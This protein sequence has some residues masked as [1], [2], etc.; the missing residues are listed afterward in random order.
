MRTRAFVGVIV[1]AG[2]LSAMTFRGQAQAQGKLPP[3]HRIA[4]SFLPQQRALSESKPETKPLTAAAFEGKWDMSIDT[5]NGCVEFGL[6]VKADPK[7]PKKITGTVSSQMDITPFEGEVV[8]GKIA[9]RFTMNAIS[10]T[11]VGS[12]QKDGSLS[13]TFNF[14]QGES[15]WRATREKR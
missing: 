13:G 1:A 15:Q 8:D 9:I 4:G 2:I 5:V 7:E 10:V 14:G 3:K 11:F 12:Q 6:E